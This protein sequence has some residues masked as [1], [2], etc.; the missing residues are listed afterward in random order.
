MQHK[1]TSRVGRGI[2]GILAAAVLIS[3]FA[4]IAG[5]SDMSKDTQSAATDDN[6]RSYSRKRLDAALKGNKPIFVN[7]TADWCI[8]CKV[9]ER[10]ALA[11]TE[12]RRLFDQNGVVYFK[13]D[14][15]NRDPA[16]TKYLNKYGRN[17]VPIYVY[18]A[19]PDSSGQR[20]EPAVMPQILS[21]KI[22]R[23]MLENE[24][25]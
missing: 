19:P 12:T 9:N 8:T 2:V 22:I 3:G 14:W 24:T 4:P 13:G 25:S 23:D 1:P 21:Q 16:I 11:T 15:T 17:G 18:Y 10:R 5:L 7:M 20:P 6:W